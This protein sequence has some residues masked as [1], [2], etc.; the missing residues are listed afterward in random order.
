MSKQKFFQLIILA[1]VFS[2]CESNAQNVKID[3]L[4]KLLKTDKQDTNK[5]I[6][7]NKLAGEYINL[8]SYDEALQLLNFVLQLSDP[9]IKQAKDPEFSKVTQRAKAF[10]YNSIG[11]IS[12][13][14]GNYPEALKNYNASLKIK[15]SVGDKKGIAY[16]KNNIGNI[17]FYKG[18]Y[19][20][21]LKN[22][23][24][25]LKLREAIGDKLGLAAIYG[26]IGSVYYAQG[27]HV[28]ALNN[29]SISLKLYLELGNKYG[30]ANTYNNIGLIYYGQNNYP[31]ALK[32]HYAALK[33][34]EEI[35][36][37]AG[38]ES[39]YNNIGDVYND[40]NIYKEA[41]QNYYFSLKIKEELGDKAGMAITY[42]N[43]AELFIKQRKFQ[44]SKRYL[45]M[46]EEVAKQMGFKESLRNTYNSY[47]KLDSATGNFKDAFEDHKLY[48]IYSDSLNNEETKEKIV[49]STM[50]Y[51]FEKKELANKAAQ[52]KIDLINIEE[53]QK[54]QIV[55]YGVV[56]VLFV[57]LIFSLFL[58]NRFRI[59]QKQKQVIEKQKSLVDAAYESLH[60]K[61]KEVMDS[62][63]Y[64][65]R[66]QRALLPSSNYIAGNLKR[67][68]RH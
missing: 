20:E 31:E 26:N 40:Q 53:K 60:E 4:R 46:A 24:V 49:Q 47:T 17:N 34:R 52:D 64:A 8:G 37:K 6:H 38:I 55:I 15:E 33:I 9:L 57:V 28:E 27:N 45:S 58:F 11:M 32:N 16:T 41:L 43:I 18:N 56:G 67:L 3:S 68:I 36:D 44:E 59:A 2:F 21:A 62:I 54:Q 51:E 61:N 42:N 50:E 7:L 12:A 35:G 22:Y 39:C 65:S 30:I 23:L 66:I 19:A 48:I 10:A 63:N 13:N 14:R 29:N 1:A 5:L 25:S